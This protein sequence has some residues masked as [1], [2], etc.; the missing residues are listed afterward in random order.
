MCENNGK[1]LEDVPQ[2]A[3]THLNMLQAII[4]R[5]S[6]N[7]AS[8]KTWCVT[9]VSGLMAV[10]LTNSNSKFIP[11][12]IIPIL[13][14]FMLDA[15]YLALEKRFRG[16]R[17][18][19]NHFIQKMHSNQLI[20]SDLFVISPAGRMSIA[21]LKSFLSFSVLPFYMILLLLIIIFVK[22]V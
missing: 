1:I 2:S 9:L 15:Y 3:Q 21:L 18:S 19:H 16:F 14:F 5:M 4:Q 17:E 10:L 22:L 7:S 6:N 8:C 12:L 13:P 20:V 11:I